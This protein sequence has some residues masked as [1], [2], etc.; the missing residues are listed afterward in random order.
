M[1]DRFDVRGRVIIVT[2][3]GKGIGKVYAD[4]LAH[5]GAKVVA[6][7]IDEEA[8][9]DVATSISHRGEQ[10]I[11]LALDVADGASCEAMAA[12]TLEAY[13]AIDVLINNASLM[14]ALPRRPWTEIPPDEW[15]RVMAVNL[16]GMFLCCRAVFPT[17]Q[18][19][20]YGKIINISSNR[21]WEGSPNRLHYTTSKA[22]VIGFTR[23]LSREVGQHGVTVNAVTP[24]FTLSETQL[25]SSDPAYLKQRSY[26]EQA[27][28]RPQTPEDLV[29]AV[30]F[31]ASSASDFM[32]GQTLNVDGGKTMH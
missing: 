26:S 19:R 4:Q 2:G 22:G 30:L 17:M 11:S 31:L 9:R 12:A 23:A 21:V 8:A 7:D 15:D 27:I 3:G 5:A 14:S 20:G 32:S 28:Q 13:G 1:T 18:A 29:G 6:A 10:A 24:G 16:R 25:Q